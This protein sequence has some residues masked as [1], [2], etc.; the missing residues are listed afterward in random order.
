MDSYAEWCAASGEN[1]LVLPMA[2]TETMQGSI[3]DA[4]G[5]GRSG[6][7]KLLD[8][9]AVHLKQAE[10]CLRKQMDPSD[11]C[12]LLVPLAAQERGDYYSAVVPL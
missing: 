10:A 1:T 2:L 3:F 6:A 7:E 11:A 8:A 12:L 5:H 4:G 9:A